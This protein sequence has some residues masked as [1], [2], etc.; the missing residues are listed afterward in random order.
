MRN[1]RR[2]ICRDEVSLSA[3][4]TSAAMNAHSSMTTELPQTSGRKQRVPHSTKSRLGGSKS[5]DDWSEST[6]IGTKEFSLTLME[7]LSCPQAQRLIDL[8]EDYFGRSWIFCRHLALLLQ[9]F[10]PYGFVKQTSHF[11]TYRVEL[12]VKHCLSWKSHMPMLQISCNLYL[13]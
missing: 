4:M 10:L 1:R 6:F 13:K 7:M 11:G 8:F 12:L 2:N 3:E 9:C 5:D